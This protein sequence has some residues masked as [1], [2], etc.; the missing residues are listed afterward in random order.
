MNKTIGHLFAIAVTLASHLG[1]GGATDSSESIATPTPT[2]SNTAAPTA[3]CVPGEQ[4]DCQCGGGT[5]GK[6]ACA[7]DGKSFGDCICV[8]KPEAGTDAQPDAGNESGCVPTLTIEEVDDVEVMGN[9]DDAGLGSA[10]AYPAGMSD[11]V[12]LGF[13][14]SVDGCRDVEITDLTVRFSN[15]VSGN[16]LHIEDTWNFDNAR[17]RGAWWANTLAGPVNMVS[18]LNIT[19]DTADANFHDPITIGMGKK[20]YIR[21]TLN[22]APTEAYPGTLYNNTF[23]THVLSLSTADQT[24]V[25]IKTKDVIKTVLPPETTDA[26]NDADSAP[27]CVTDDDCAKYNGVCLIFWC[28][29]GTCFVDER[30]DDGDNHSLCGGG[31]PGSWDCDDNDPSVN[32]YATE[33][34]DGKDNDCDGEVDEGCF[35]AAY[36]EPWTSDPQEFG[37]RGCCGTFV[38]TNAL[39]A[40]DLIKGSSHPVYYYGSDGKRYI[41]TTSVV[42]DSWYAPIDYTYLPQHDYHAVCNNVKE[43]TDAQLVAIP[44]GGNVTMR[45]GTYITGITTDPKRYVVDTHHTLRWTSPDV[46]E[47]LY[48]GSV[49]ERTYLTPDSFFVNYVIGSSVDSASDFLWVTKYQQADIEV[50]IGAKP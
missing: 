23:K 44:L 24:S 11:A 50:E 15:T 38:K 17:L 4:N 48:P 6:Q 30:D 33:A 1:C 21:F 42:L 34:C 20:E 27:Q 3:T 37:Y 29:V 10:Y 16:T 32:P 36:C 28:G 8:P 40:G 49:A 13:Y 14:V 39:V 18:V 47:Q 12:F 43:L 25:A 22:I 7:K 46:L 26:G 9:P 5:E 41:F 35:S 2:A 19:G 45:P 31:K